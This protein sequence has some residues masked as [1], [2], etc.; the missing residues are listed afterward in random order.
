MHPFRK[1][2]S[3][4]IGYYDNIRVYPSFVAERIIPL[5]LYKNHLC[6]IWKSEAVIFQNAI[7]ELKAHFKVVENHIPDKHVESFLKSEFEPKKISVNQYDCSIQ[8]RLKLV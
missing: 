6:L 5:F 1:K 4:N 8:K 7:D 3:I 2:Y